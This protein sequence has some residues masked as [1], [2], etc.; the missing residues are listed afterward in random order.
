MACQFLKAFVNPEAHVAPIAIVRILGAPHEIAKTQPAKT[1]MYIIIVVT[2]D[3]L[4][5]FVD[6]VFVDANSS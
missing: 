1:T 2:I 3:E 4:P 6:S 5:L